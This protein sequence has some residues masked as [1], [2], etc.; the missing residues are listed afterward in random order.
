[1]ETADLHIVTQ[2]SMK[3]AGGYIA[4]DKLRVG[5]VGCGAIGREHIAR[6]TDKFSG[7]D[8]VAV[9]DVFVEGAR[10][11]GEPLG[12]SIYNN[13]TDLVYDDDV[14]AVICTSPGFAHK[15]TILQALEAGKPVFTEKPLSMS[16][17]DSR[18][19][20]EAEQRGGKKLIQVGF[21]RRYDRGYRQMKALLDEGSFGEALYSRST[22]WNV[23]VGY[24]YDTQMVVTDACIHEID[25][26]HWLMNDEY[27]SAQVFMPKQSKYANKALKDPQIMMLRS[28]SGRIAT[29]EAFLNSR[30][31]CD[32]NCEIVCEEGTIELPA[33]PYPTVRKNGGLTV[34]IEQNWK[35]RFVDAY[36]AEIQDWIDSTIKGEVN[37]PN[38]WDGY[39]AN[40]AMEALTA[41]QLSGEAEPIITGEKPDFYK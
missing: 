33:P 41:A 27:V 30:V 31:G 4:M 14:D 7:A 2:D 28:K 16:A 34:P 37:G 39:V 22:H 19:I 10:K 36:D 32:I 40:V 13:S 21:M 38:A 25:M 20:M 17:A 24:D 15:E 29:I 35:H 8:V 26:L 1:M 18:E 5:V 3:R 23:Q 6:I 12:A 9:S 11:I